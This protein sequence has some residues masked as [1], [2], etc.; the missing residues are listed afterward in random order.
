[1]QK[2]KTKIL[3]L[4][5]MLVL[6]SVLVSAGIF[7]GALKSWNLKLQNV[8]YQ[9]NADLSQNIVIVEIDNKSLD[10]ASG[11]GRFQN[12]RRTFYAKALNEIEKGSPKAVAFDI[13]FSTRTRGIP[14]DAMKAKFNEIKS[15][16]PENA[17]D[18]V[19][20][21]SSFI[22]KD[23]H[24]DDIA[25]ADE[26]GKYGN[27][28]IA[29]NAVIQT[30]KPQSYL[31]AT[32][33]INPIEII[34]KSAQTGNVSVLPDADNVV[35][36]IPLAVIYKED[37]N[38]NLPLAIAQF[39]Y[40]NIAYP[41]GSTPSSDGMIINYK[42]AV[43]ISRFKKFSFV[44]VY[45]GEVDPSEFKDKIVMIGATAKS[46]QD[47]QYTPISTS[48]PMSGVE[49]QAQAIETILNK[50]YLVPQSRTMTLAIC[51]ILATITILF[52]TNF[53]FIAGILIIIILSGLHFLYAKY[54][55][56]KTSNSAE[57]ADM[58]Y[59]YLSIL[60]AYISS[61]IYRY[62]AEY[63]AKSA[64]K[65]AFGHYVNESVVNEIIK[66]PEMLKL[67]GEKK[68]IS[69]FFT[70]IE[71][72]TSYSELLPPEMLTNILNKYFSAM[73]KVILAHGGT[74][75]KFE[76]DAIMAFFNAPIDQANHA[77]LACRTILEM[78]RALEEFN[79]SLKIGNFQM[80]NFRSGI[81]TGPAIVG[82]LGS[83]NRFDY[84]IIGD[85]VNTA[86]RLESANKQF[87]TNIIVAEPTYEL[88]KDKFIFREID[89]IR[90][91]GKLKPIHIYELMA[92][93]NNFSEIGA[94]LKSEFEKAL[95]MYRECR[96]EEAKTAFEEAL[97]IYPD[98]GP[99]KTY[100]SRC[101]TFIKNHPAWNWD[102]VWQMTSK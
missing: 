63:K 83:E 32:S 96:F 85:T 66:H 40:P 39:A 57:I 12:W 59:P 1:M 26:L 49:I 76:G 48:T 23:N 35:R 42:G 61:L 79:N 65:N 55:F 64:I 74:L 95:A 5:G 18:F 44:D 84:T 38:L 102:G 33:I 43:G 56:D 8:L 88:T 47:L 36:R 75:D 90:V 69:V 72:F 98:D 62:F 71:G 31:S 46:L 45:N 16:T 20:F 54:M 53:H 17:K 50:D 24:P 93:K 80:I 70:D 99:S 13:L 29:Q 25:F 101:E 4:A 15:L 27:V 19:D 52:A 51:F 78:R 77:E 14:E 3:A 10:D 21:L 100:I 91:V 67:G 9:K 30:E 73:S 28:F 37:P 41:A 7:S 58:V 11:L 89:L 97:K 82:N 87:G 22:F 68:E 6:V 94:S 81:T 34:R 2:I 86:S 92:E 60:L